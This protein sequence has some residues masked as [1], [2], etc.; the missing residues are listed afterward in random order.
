MTTV[1]QGQTT[2]SAS[3]FLRPAALKRGPTP[4]QSIGGKA[5]WCPGGGELIRNHRDHDETAVCPEKGRTGLTTGV[6][7][8]REVTPVWFGGGEV[9]LHFAEPTYRGE[10]PLFCYWPGQSSFRWEASLG[11]ARKPGLIRT[12]AGGAWLVRAQIAPQAN[13]GWQSLDLLRRFDCK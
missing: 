7:E 6:I 1:G 12:L 8:W 10:R 9:S 2:Q 5:G 4:G 11:T 3:R 13:D